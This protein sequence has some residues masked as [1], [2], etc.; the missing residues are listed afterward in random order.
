MQIFAKYL[1]SETQETAITAPAA[2]TFRISMAMAAMAAM[3]VAQSLPDSG[4]SVFFIIPLGD[5]H[6][7]QQNQ[8][9]SL[10]IHWIFIG[11]SLDMQVLSKKNFNLLGAM[12]KKNGNG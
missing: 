2:L 9:N 3:A 11:Y 5:R 4:P 6:A 8:Q 10:D 1:G 12:K 7:L